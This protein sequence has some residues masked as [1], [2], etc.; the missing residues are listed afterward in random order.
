MCLYLADETR[1]RLVAF[2]RGDAGKR[3]LARNVRRAEHDVKAERTEREN[4]ERDDGSH[5]SALS[6]A[7]ARR[8]NAGAGRRICRGQQ[9]ARD[10]EPRR[11]GLGLADQAAGAIAVDFLELVLIDREVATAHRR[12]RGAPKRPDNGKDRRRGHQ[13]KND[14]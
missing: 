3:R 9:A 6:F 13:C 1:N 12:P 8:G 14:P 7:R 4:G 2:G 5:T 11:L 10:F